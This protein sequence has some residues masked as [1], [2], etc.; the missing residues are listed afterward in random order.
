MIAPNLGGKLSFEDLRINNELQ[1]ANSQLLRM[2]E[3]HDVF[4]RNAS[5]EAYCVEQQRQT[6]RKEGK[7]KQ[8]K[9][10]SQTRC[11]NKR[12]IETSRQ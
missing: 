8:T 6:R 3:K 10:H 11:L 2:N 4:V 1:S 7:K 5:G 12:K 9:H